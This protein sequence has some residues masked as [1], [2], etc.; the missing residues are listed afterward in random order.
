LP[1]C[2]NQ[3]QTETIIV[4]K[5]RALY[6]TICLI[7]GFSQLTQVLGASVKAP[8]FTPDMKNQSMHQRPR[9]LQATSDPASPSAPTQPKTCPGPNDTKKDTN[10]WP[11]DNKCHTKPAAK[12]E[13]CTD[14]LKP[15]RCPYAHCESSYSKC[16]YK[17]RSCHEP[18]KPYSCSNGNCEANE[19]E[20]TQNP[21]IGM[22]KPDGRIPVCKDKSQKRCEDGICRQ[23][24]AK[25]KS[26]RCPLDRPWNCGFNKCTANYGECALFSY[27]PGT[28][29]FVCGNGECKRAIESCSGVSYGMALT[30]RPIQF[31]WDSTHANEQPHTVKY[32]AG[33]MITFTSIKLFD[34]RAT[35]QV[36]SAD[37][38]TSPYQHLVDDP[39]KRPDANNQTR[40]LYQP[41]RPK[42][43]AK[44]IVEAIARSEIADVKN[45]FRSKNY[46]NQVRPYFDVRPH[47]LKNHKWSYFLPDFL[48]IR[49]VVLK[50]STTGRPGNKE[51]FGSLV[52]VTFSVDQIRSNGAVP[53]NLRD[54]F[55]LGRINEV[56]KWDCHT[57]ESPDNSNWNG[58]TG[59][60]LDYDIEMPGTYAVIMRPAFAPNQKPDAYTG[61]LV[62]NKKTILFFTF[63]LMPIISV[64]SMLI[65]RLFT[66]MSECETMSKDRQ[67]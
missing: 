34:V 11:V 44:L 10:L 60:K 57:R 8:S 27:C 61:M 30:D 36:F 58:Q 20:C 52:R 3:N 16:Q 33:R 45:D 17:I 15:F 23:D 19:Q 4:K 39:E 66:F 25:L 50:I 2:Y 56:K 7:I 31:K 37:H 24:C 42:V 26:S 67:F 9:E 14:W 18:Q 47:E 49:S 6:L 65:Y 35:G 32:T 22:A 54:Q 40:K 64:V 29:P 38:L 46:Y 59:T 48:S 43:G 13:V 55:C 53:R 62:K 21:I 28:A 1:K 12:D 5:M 63:W 41:N 51:R